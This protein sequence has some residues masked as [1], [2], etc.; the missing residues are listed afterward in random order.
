MESN[1][2]ATVGQVLADRFPS[3]VT[4]IMVAAAMTTTKNLA[5][6]TLMVERIRAQETTVEGEMIILAPHHM[7]AKDA[8]TLL[9]TVMARVLP[10]G[11][12][13]LATVASDVTML[14]LTS[15][16]LLAMVVSDVKMLLLPPA[17]I[18][19]TVDSTL[20]PM[21]GDTTAILEETNVEMTMTTLVLD[22]VDARNNRVMDNGMTPAHMRLGEIDRASGQLG[23]VMPQRMAS[24]SIWATARETKKD[25]NNPFAKTTTLMIRTMKS[26]SMASTGIQVVIAAMKGRRAS[27][28]PAMAL[29]PVTH[30][31]MVA[32]TILMVPSV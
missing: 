14:L 8:T 6:H 18:A 1:L 21:E 17:V 29:P 19:G 24:Q 26:G 5:P 7:G 9:P 15:A 31:A 23:L 3:A 20:L 12:V 27:V 25:T 16:A 32:E 30:Q 10:T 2:G 22:T 28:S 4:M 11:V 13:I